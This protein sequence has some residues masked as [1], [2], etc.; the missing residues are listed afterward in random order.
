MPSLVAVNTAVKKLSLRP[1]ICAWV[2]VLMAKALSYPTSCLSLFEL[3][4]VHIYW[5]LAPCQVL[6]INK[7]DLRGL[8]ELAKIVVINRIVEMCCDF[9]FPLS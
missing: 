6:S 8:S 9:T 7:E 5:A 2:K 3:L 4:L 1:V